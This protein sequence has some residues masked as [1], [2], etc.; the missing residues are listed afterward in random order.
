MNFNK[1]IKRKILVGLVVILW[2]AVLILYGPFYARGYPVPRSIGVLVIALGV[3][4]VLFVMFS[5]KPN[6]K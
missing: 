3:F 6:S 2:G 1:L 5:K 4:Y